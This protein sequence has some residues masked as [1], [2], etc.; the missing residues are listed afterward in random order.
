MWS[1][2]SCLKKKV[3]ELLKIR[4][5]LLI[6]IDGPLPDCCLL[7]EHYVIEVESEITECTCGKGLQRRWTEVRHPV[8]LAIGEPEII[9]R[10]KQCP[11]CK[12]SFRSKEIEKFIAPGCCYAFDVVAVV[13]LA[14]YLYHWQNA[15]IQHNIFRRFKLWIPTSTINNLA[16]YF[17]DYLAGVHYSASK[18]IKALINNNGGYI[19]HADGTC[20]VGTDTIFVMIDGIT[21]LVLDASKMP[22]ENNYDIEYLFK[23]VV[24]LFGDPL[25][26]MRDLSSR[27][28]K[29]HENVVTEDVV[30]FVCHYH[31]LE[32]VGKY[33]CRELHGK[34][35]TTMNKHK[36]RASL[37]SLRK[38]LVRYSKTG[39]AISEEEIS[40][41][42][43]NPNEML[44]LDHV[45]LRRYL[46]YIL[47]RW[48][49]DYTAGFKGEH[50]PFELPGL[51]FYRR[52][53]KL[54]DGL[55]QILN[56]Y[57]LRPHEL[58]TLQTVMKKLAP[59]REDAKLVN[60][61]QRLEK[62][63]NIFTALRKALRFEN[64]GKKP[65]SRRHDMAMTIKPA[66]KL[67]GRL[68]AFRARLQKTIETGRDPDRIT[69]SKTVIRYL[70]KYWDQLF[71]HVIYVEGRK[72]PIL[73]MRTNYVA[74]HKFGDSKQGLRRKVGTKKLA[75]YIQ[76]MR[77]E[78]MFVLNLAKQDYLDIVCGG[79][80]NNLS[81]YFAQHYKSGMAIRKNRLE[82]KT[83]HPMP[84][85]KK[86]IRE[87]DLLFKVVNGIKVYLEMMTPCSRAV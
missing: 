50:F 42:L 81:A 57:K 4:S 8:G 2:T 14:R 61:V 60:L 25:A 26:I 29:A 32:N 36:I 55:G 21:G 64:P 6:E 76:A 66:L 56:A 31:F 28:A 49:A 45:Q 51:V 9:H 18:A 77:P 84:V 74:E 30:L 17:L 83:S 19:I 82:R 38:D 70:D 12:T 37:R 87:S 22:A 10:V 27:I 54:Y 72:D 53:I 86:K 71:G 23:Q 20:E 39:P 52:C 33:L 78:E 35:T 73:A 16:N 1:I 68:K 75:R 46:A 44:D 62:A 7:P 79:T 85:S 5:E 13:G 65:L 63:E 24:K 67:E 80:P 41:Y 15:E 48:L 34:L 43:D 11:G 3:F 59:V 40:K 69:D 58:Q 47:L